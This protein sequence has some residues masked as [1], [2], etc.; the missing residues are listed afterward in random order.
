MR[1][2]T[3]V[4]PVPGLPVNFS[5]LPRER[6]VAAPPLGAHTEEILGDVAQLPDGAIARLF[7]Q[8]IV[9]SP[10]YSAARPAA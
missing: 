9:Q 3:V 7:D 4:L 2:A 8:G 1:S 10:H 5:T 6:P